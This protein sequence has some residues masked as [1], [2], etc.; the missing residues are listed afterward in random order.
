MELTRV[1]ENDKDSLSNHINYLDIVDN[2]II[3]EDL[4]G[5][6]VLKLSLIYEELFSSKD[7]NNI[8]DKLMNL[9]NA[10]KKEHNLQFIFEKN[11]DFEDIIEGH[12]KIN[13]SDDP[14]I[15]DLSDSRIKQIKNDRDSNKLFRYNLYVVITKQFENKKFN[16]KDYFYLDKEIDQKI[17]SFYKNMI[18]ELKM[19]ENYYLNYLR[20][21]KI[22][23]KKLE[24]QET[25]DFLFNQINLNDDKNNKFRFKEDLI[26][27]DLLD[28]D[29]YLKINNKYLRILTFNMKP[30]QKPEITE[31]TIIKKIMLADL[32]FEYKI[33]V[34]IKKLDKEIQK[35]EIRNE[36]K[37]KR[38]INL[39]TTNPR[40]KSADDEN[41]MDQTDLTR[42]LIDLREGK[43][44]LFH[45]EFLV[46]VTGESEKELR[47]NVDSMSTNIQEMSSAKEFKETIA[48][49]PL[50]LATLPGNSKLNNSRNFRVKTS[51]LADL[52]PVYGPPSS[53]GKPVFILR[54]NYGSIT[55]IDPFNKKYPNF[56]AVVAGGSGGG[57]SFV[58]SQMLSNLLNSDPLITIIELGDSYKKFV[59]ESGGEYYEINEGIGI[60]PFDIPVREKE[61]YWEKTL[62]SMVRDEGQNLTKDHKGIIRD[63]IRTI[64]SK[65][66]EKPIISDFVN[67][68]ENNLEYEEKELEKIRKKYI[69]YLKMFTKGEY[70]KFLNNKDSSIDSSSNIKGYNVK[71]LQ[72]SKE[73]MEIFMIY[74]N[75][76]VEHQTQR[77]PDKVKSLV[78]DEAWTFMMNERGI[79]LIKKHYRTSRKNKMMVIAISQSPGDFANEKFQNDVMI[80]IS[81]TYI[82]K[83]NNN[84]AY[85]QLK[86]SFN[87]TD[88][89]LKQ[90]ENLE[91][92][93]GY[94]STFFVKNP[95]MKARLKLVPTP[96]SYWYSTTTGDDKKLFRKYLKENDYDE[97]K[98]KLYLAEHYP[99]GTF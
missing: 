68:A 23:I 39:V 5:S 28:Y 63:L 10:K 25:I 72:E 56:N 7:K 55:T 84:T 62:E 58:I 14:T 51:Y 73:L 76:I 77:A 97:R 47:K 71:G 21:L 31:P 96:Y 57:K 49:Y 26:C 43:E 44:N 67:A 22:D 85:K 53:T 95:D 6:V 83:F 75:G 60:N 45:L 74:M 36:R 29:D 92:I 15:T 8:S 12:Q 9:L 16:V 87:L 98:T 4:R 54:N 70:G 3:F 27:N 79:E 59:E 13:E 24:E 82:M 65:K 93:K 37:V 32:D 11:K 90:I 40:T 2:K 33:V 17:T 86:E 30:E 52:I 80:N 48:N 20:R 66:I 35:K 61:L 78:L 34:N 50:Y 69:R 18:N 88:A 19:M 1:R 99:H 91:N 46:V 81:Y 94:H 42:L 41:E 89:D 64:K 38:I